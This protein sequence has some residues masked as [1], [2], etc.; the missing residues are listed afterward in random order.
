MRTPCSI[1]RLTNWPNIWRRAR[2]SCWPHITIWAPRW[3]WP[4]RLDHDGMRELSPCAAVWHPIGPRGP[5][6]AIRGSTPAPRP[7]TTNSPNTSP[8]DSTAV[9][10]QTMALSVWHPTNSGMQLYYFQLQ[11]EIAGFRRAVGPL[12]VREPGPQ[13]RQRGYHRH[14]GQRSDALHPRSHAGHSIAR[15]LGR[16]AGSGADSNSLRGCC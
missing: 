11:S 15:Q 12:A 13:H 2:I 4:C 8:F 1:P 16:L 6:G 10:S 9:S 7:S 3:T 14:R 5:T